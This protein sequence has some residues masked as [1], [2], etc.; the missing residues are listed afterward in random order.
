MF[1]LA[2]ILAAVNAAVL[3]PEERP[4]SFFSGVLRPAE[5]SAGDIG[6]QRGLMVV[7]RDGI[8]L[9]TDLYLPP[10][11]GK[12]PTI[13]MRTPYGKEGSEPLLR[14]VA[15]YGYA[16]VAQDCRGTGASEPGQWDMYM[17][18]K[19]DGQDLLNWVE[20]QSWSNGKVGG[21]GGS[22]VGETQWFMAS[23][24]GMTAILPEVAGLGDGSSPGVRLHMMVNAYARTI[25]KSGGRAKASVSLDE[26]ERQM[27]AETLSTG[28]FNDPLNGPYPE[29]MLE[30]F[31]VLRA[32]APAARA[33]RLLQ[34]WAELPPAERTALVRNLLGASEVNYANLGNLPAIFGP[35]GGGPAFKYVAPS[36]ADVYRSIAAPPLMLNGW[37]DWGLDLTLE[38]WALI[39]E[40]SNPHVRDNAVMV[41]TPSAHNSVGYNEG[42]DVTPAL[43]YRYRGLDNLELIVRWY[44]RWLKNRPDAVE[45]LSR[46][47]YYMMGANQWRGADAWPP[48]SA[49]PTR[50][51]LDSGGSASGVHGSGI[52]RR[53]HVGDGQP[54]RFTYDPEHPPPT[55]GGSIVSALVPSG[56]LDQSETQ[57]REDVLV[58][59]TAPLESDLGVVGPVHAL[60]HASSSAVD[61][62]WTAKLTDVFPDG[63]ALVL[64]SGIVRARFRNRGEDPSLIEPGR[65][66]PYD[67]DMWA[68]ANLFRKGHRIRLE[69][70]SADFPRYE[71]NT[72]RGG[73]PGSPLKATQTVFH[74]RAYP[75]HL[76][77]HV[78]DEP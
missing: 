40:F 55:R 52:L 1:L 65:V 42:A 51:F 54:D 11:G 49:R 26:I 61:T 70:A 77:L 14:E 63:R 5:Y 71:R 43:R 33:E 23:N 2:T 3:I 41:I 7:A 73:Q 18:E 25:G 47:T 6:V 34:I 28:Y 44:D 9:A 15:R 56:S 16:V 12:L 53:E 32:L 38:T 62:D 46:V 78:M 75:S 72:N 76:V 10:G 20:A 36:L 4:Y 30:R 37:Y 19:E 69:I 59:T 74:E 48:R 66:Y 67:I 58:Y 29:R 57:E 8:R 17:Y 13:I 39:E 27:E 60:I 21:V 22:Y 24:K 45:G 50:F 35:D 31:P 68:T 64:Q